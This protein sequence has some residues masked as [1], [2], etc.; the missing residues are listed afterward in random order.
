MRTRE[1]PKASGKTGLALVPLGETAQLKVRVAIS[2]STLELESP[3]VA[4]CKLQVPKQ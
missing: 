2:L 1:S 3:C 4:N